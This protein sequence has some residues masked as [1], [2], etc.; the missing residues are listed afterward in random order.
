M[1]SCCLI[2]K[3]ILKFYC[4]EKATP[5]LAPL[6]PNNHQN[7]FLLY[8]PSHF[9]LSHDFSHRM[10][11]DFSHRM[12]S[13]TVFVSIISNRLWAL[14]GPCLNHLCFPL[15]LVSV[16]C[17]TGVLMFKISLFL[18]PQVLAIVIRSHIFHMHLVT[19]LL[20]DKTTYNFIQESSSIITMIYCKNTTNN[21][22]MMKYLMVSYVWRVNLTPVAV[23]LL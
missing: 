14:L 11:H 2:S 5:V 20:K 19:L 21:G 16:L 13:S 6:A 3:T 22:R 9:L 8:I 4:V 10:S 17:I 12:P 18:L 1:P 23:Q 7:Y 15:N